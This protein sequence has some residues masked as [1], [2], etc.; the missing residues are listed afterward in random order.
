MSKF[1]TRALLF[2]GTLFGA[3]LA[4]AAPEIE[5]QAGSYATYRVESTVYGNVSKVDSAY[6]PNGWNAYAVAYPD[7]I[8]VTWDAD[9]TRIRFQHD[10]HPTTSIWDVYSVVGFL[11]NFTVTQDA[12]AT[13]EWAAGTWGDSQ[14]LLYDVTADVE[15]VSMDDVRVGRQQVALEAG[16]EYQIV[17]STFGGASGGGSYGTLA[18]GSYACGPADIDA[19]GVLNLDD[20]I[21]YADAFNA[22]CP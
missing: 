21:L 5:Y 12:P 7:N 17:M 19:N 1:A 20:I 15:L 8:T 13:M 10:R 9:A 2:G 14:A 11:A 16:H 4:Q 18:L 3:G 6:P 22:G